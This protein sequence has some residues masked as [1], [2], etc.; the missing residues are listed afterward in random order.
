MSWGSL[1]PWLW[2]LVL[3]AFA[4]APVWGESGDPAATDEAAK[5]EDIAE[6]DKPAAKTE[7]PA[8]EAEKP[9]AKAD[10]PAAKAEEPAKDE[11]PKHKVEPKLFK[12][13]LSLT[14]AFEAA[15]TAEVRV[16]LEEH[17]GLEVVR[18]VPHGATVKRGEALVEFD[19]KKIDETLADLQRDIELAGL[20]LKEAEEGLAVLE[21]TTPLD[22]AEAARAQ[23]IAK[24]DAARY[25]EVERDLSKKS[26]D[27]QLQSSQNNLDYEK[28]ELRQLEKMY[29]ADDVTEETEEIILKRQ[30]DAV[31][32]SEFSFLMAKHR[33]QESLETDM[34][35]EEERLRD[36]TQR[37][38]L[39]GEKA[40]AVL[41]LLLRQERLSLEKKKVARER[42]QKKLKRLEADRAAMNVTSPID[43]VVYYGQFTRGKWSGAVSLSEKL[44]PGGSV[45]AGDVFMTVVKTRPMIVRATV[46]E[47]DLRWVEPGLKVT[48]QPTALPRVNLTGS[49]VDVA[50]VP[51]N[52][53]EFEV[54]IRV[55]VDKRAAALVPGMGC[56]VKAV[57]YANKEALVAPVKSVF[58][59]DLDPAKQFV[60]L[61]RE[62]KEPK[63][64]PV[65]VGEKNDESAEILK[66]LAA[67]DE[68]LLEKP[69]AKK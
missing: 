62:G 32:Y 37:A 67:G 64:Q 23:R 18:A 30:R 22:L 39:T 68:I 69:K 5:I 13:D 27:F 29:K 35:R 54:R 43:G 28:E 40:K 66:G 36:R 38:E 33:H 10:E 11:A 16:R 45:T 41:P 26:L 6:A 63:K 55:N 47:K 34:P 42:N 12:A 2:C 44:R 65:T 17:S 53:G 48:V 60:Y 49:V 46:S 58:A 7:E 50:S 61:V 14:G 56:S 15:A 52:D 19:M 1:R 9:A 21:A 51:F 8:T 25:F 57:P 24:E 59:D 20:E 4:A 3:G 31:A